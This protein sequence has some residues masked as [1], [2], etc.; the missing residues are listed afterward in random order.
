MTNKIYY[1][2]PR[3]E[4]DWWYPEENF[5]RDFAARTVYEEDDSYDTGMLDANGNKIMARIKKPQIGFT[6]LR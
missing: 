6:R 1:V 5:T 4:D 2:K 3:A